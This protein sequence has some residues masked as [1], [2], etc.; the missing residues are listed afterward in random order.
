M[1][2]NILLELFEVRR[3]TMRKT[4]ITVFAFM[5]IFGF[6]LSGAMAQMVNWDPPQLITNTEQFDDIGVDLV[7]NQLRGFVSSV[8][9]TITFSTDVISYTQASDMTLS[10]PVVDSAL[11][12]NGVTY[13][14]D[15]NTVGIWVSGTTYTAFPVTEQPNV[16]AEGNPL[17]AMVGAYRFIAAGPD[18]KLYILFQDTEDPGLGGRYLLVGNPAVAT[19]R[20]TPRSLNQNSKGNWVTCKISGLPEGHA[21]GD[22]NLGDICITGIDADY[23]ITPVCQSSGPSNNHNKKKVMLKLD[24]QELIGAIPDVTGTVEI[25]VIGTVGEAALPF[26]GTDTIKTKAPKVPK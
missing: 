5:I 22:I 6:A 19:V 23:T 3:N 17:I 25:T 18:G 4:L 15:A 10:A 11:S 16:P 1:W 21:V 24:R 7:T 12:P 9:Y 13:A 8:P 26:V 20:L 2:H 14:I